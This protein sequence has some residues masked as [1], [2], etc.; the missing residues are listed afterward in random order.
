MV[1]I[2]EQINYWKAGAQEDWE[3]AQQLLAGGKV[4]HSLFF[5]HLALEKL[6]KAHICRYKQEIA[7]Q[8]H[9]L[10]RLAQLTG[11]KLEEDRLDILA[12]MNEFNIEGRYPL[13]YVQPPTIQEAF[14]YM[15]KAEKVYQWLIRQL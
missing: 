6:L 1:D 2:S 14:E 3:A 15:R 8:S 7:P 13:N 12:E 11:L 5:A 9:N 10:V 4:R